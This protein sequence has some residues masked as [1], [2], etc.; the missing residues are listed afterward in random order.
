[1]SLLINYI[2]KNVIKNSYVRHL[3]RNDKEFNN[4]EYKLNIIKKYLSRTHIDPNLLDSLMS[5]G[6]KMTEFS[7]IS[8]C[9][10]EF[11]KNK[12][13]KTNIKSLKYVFYIFYL[14]GLKIKKRSK[15][16]PLFSII[17]NKKLNNVDILNY[18]IKLFKVDMR[19][20]TING[21]SLLHLY[22]KSSNVIKI[23]VIQLLLDNGVKINTKT[24]LYNYTPLQFYIMNNI[25]D[26]KIIDF[27]IFKGAELLSGKNE[28]PLYSLFNSCKSNKKIVTISKKFIKHGADINYKNGDNESTPIIGYFKRYYDF[29]IGVL[30][31]IVSL[32]ADTSVTILGNT[33]LHIYLSRKK[34]S[35]KVI[36]YLLSITNNINTVNNRGYTPLQVYFNKYYNEIDVSIMNHLIKNGAIMHRKISHQFNYSGFELFLRK[37]MYMKLPSYEIEYMIKNLHLINNDE[38]E[39]SPLMSSICI[40]CF[41]FVK[42]F[43]QKGYDIN[44][45]TANGET[46][47]SVCIF[48][49]NVMAFTL[50]LSSKPNKNTIIKTFDIIKEYDLSELKR[51]LIRSLIKYAYSIDTE[52]CTK[53]NYILTQ[54]SD[55]I[56]IYEKDL[57]EM[58]KTII[59]NKISVYKLIFNSD[60][61]MDIM[62]TNN[63]EVTKFKF[64]LYGRKVDDVIN[65]SII[66]HNSI[67]FI[68]Y[69][70]DEV[71]KDTSWSKLPEEIKLKI[72]YHMS[73]YEIRKLLY[74]SL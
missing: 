24:R 23:D 37:N 28:T 72:F 48:F 73:F 58:R 52:I 36:N 54:F 61:T 3:L 51:K 22:L 11:V 12:R 6:I 26:I 38:Y 5:K 1:M 35:I 8:K 10:L 14:H 41:E 15:N 70:I 18:I 65:N 74:K 71:C 16:H 27:L 50:L 53:Y 49:N 9:F 39:Y 17:K 29:N 33:L 56:D 40:N 20:K 69:N 62:Y 43:L 31:F 66:R 34:I 2:A 25:I 42:Y 67:E 21:F 63:K 7:L 13:V 46:C 19:I 64:S 55:I 60:K 59:N 68:K 30:K 32:G 44:Y 4:K 45:I 47:L 57:I